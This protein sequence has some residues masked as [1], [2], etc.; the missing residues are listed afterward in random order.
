MRTDCALSRVVWVLLM[1]EVFFI[2]PAVTGAAAGRTEIRLAILPGEGNRAPNSVFLLDAGSLSVTCL[3]TKNL[4]Y[5]PPRCSAP[6]VFGKPGVD[7][8]PAAYDGE[9][10]MTGGG[11]PLRLHRTDHPPA[12][13]RAIS[14]VKFLHPTRFGILPIAGDKS[15]LIQ[16]KQKTEARAPQ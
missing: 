12:P 6:P 4:S 7:L 11:G 16:K 5:R 9:R 3:I 2:V 10:L 14:Y 13:Y 8:W 1:L 15:W